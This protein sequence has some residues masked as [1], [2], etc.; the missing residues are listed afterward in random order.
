[1]DETPPYCNQ[2]HHCQV[3]LS[4]DAVEKHGWLNK[5]G[6]NL[7]QWR[8]RWFVQSNNYL[9]YF[10]SPQ[11]TEPRGSIPLEMVEVVKQEQGGEQGIFLVH[12]KVSA[13]V[14]SRNRCTTEPR[15]VRAPQDNFSYYLQSEDGPEDVDEWVESIKWAK[16]S[17]LKVFDTL[18]TAPF[19]PLVKFPLTLDRPTPPGG[20]LQVGRYQRQAEGAGST[21]RGA[22]TARASTCR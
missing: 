17:A 5:Q 20:V 18:S 7:G 1:M 10:K 12:H 9:F 19:V 15:L 2:Y 8:R 3:F 4:N 6:G 22:S 11:D 16:Y 21:G 14:P 13:C